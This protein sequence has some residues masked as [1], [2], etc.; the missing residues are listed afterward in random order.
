M[1]GAP[2]HAGDRP[3]VALVRCGLVMLPRIPARPGGSSDRCFATRDP[4][5][6]LSVG[7]ATEKG[8]R[9]AA[10]TLPA[11]SSHSLVGREPGP[12]FLRL[13]SCE[14][15]APDG[16]PIPDCAPPTSRRRRPP[17]VAALEPIEPP[18]HPPCPAPSRP[19]AGRVARCRRARFSEPVRGDACPVGTE[20]R[21]WCVSGNSDR[22]MASIE[23]SV[24]SRVKSRSRSTAA[25][26]GHVSGPS[27]GRR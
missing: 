7:L 15:S 10:H 19:P 17:I 2:G 5:E 25:G 18:H 27:R 4:L 26:T 21:P 24:G 13:T 23:V 22:I 9:H 11:A 14:G 3:S 8:A 1:T 12:F 16:R 6:R 20:R